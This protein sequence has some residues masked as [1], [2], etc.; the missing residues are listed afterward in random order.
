MYFCVL[1]EAIKAHMYTHYW[2]F[3]W[4]QTQSQE[5]I[6]IPVKAKQLMH[7]SHTNEFSYTEA[8]RSTV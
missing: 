6:N 1:E 5:A 2:K 7:T 8:V 4:L 3:A